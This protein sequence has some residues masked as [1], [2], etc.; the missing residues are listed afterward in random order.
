MF[1]VSPR[2][3]RADAVDAPDT[4]NELIEALWAVDAYRTAVGADM[5]LRQ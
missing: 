4:L 5:L 1:D 3:A 2:C